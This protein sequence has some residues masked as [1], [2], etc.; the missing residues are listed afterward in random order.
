MSAVKGLNPLIMNKKMKDIIVGLRGRVQIRQH[1]I[2]ITFLGLLLFGLTS[3]VNAALIGPV[4]ISIDGTMTDWT[5]PANITTNPDQ[6][7][8]DG[9]GHV[10]PST[11]LD[12]GTAPSCS[13]LTPSGRDLQT[14]AY[15]WND[16]KLF[17]YVTRWEANANVTDWW[18]YLDTSNDGRMQDGEPVLR[19]SWQGNTG[20]TDRTLYQYDAVDNAQGDLLVNP[21]GDGYTMPGD[22]I[23][24]VS[25]TSVTGGSADQ[26]AME[27]WIDWNQI[28]P[29]GPI[30]LKFHIASSNGTNLPNSII[31]NMDGPA[32]GS[33]S[34][35]DLSVTKTVSATPV[36]ATIP[37]DFVVTVTNNGD[38]DATGVSIEDV[39][40]AGLKFI[41]ATATQGSYNSSTGLWTIG[42]IPYTTPTLSSATLTLT[43]SGE[44]VTADVDILN[45]ANNLLLNEAD[46]VPG[47]NSASMT[48]RIL[49]WFPSITVTKTVLTELDPV[50]NATDPKAIP[51]AWKLYSIKLSNA[52]GPADADSV[53]VTDTIP[54]NTELF[55]GDLDAGSPVAIVQGATPSNLSLTFGGLNDLNDDIEF[56][57][58]NGN[59]WNYQPINTNGY[60]PLV[61]NIRI[62]PKGVFAAA[63]AGSPSVEFRFRVRVK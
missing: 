32:G 18:F 52:D 35:P 13:V 53:F 63:G 34:F 57:S 14:F 30:S 1:T 56:S 15:T 4:N 5:S 36:K 11:D 3:P 48:V 62:N 8:T 37:F 61:T 7:T 19:V 33:L 39:L 42:T 45:T 50:N 40:P 25:L 23:N 44:P 2:A 21:V 29:G 12:T 16:T 24:G 27:S 46:P 9:D 28:G 59:N 26:K 31:D 38:A 60:D 10:C 43:V 47:N 41:S 17:I 51:G 6:S 20:N 58:D 55:V 54:V 22:V 49:A